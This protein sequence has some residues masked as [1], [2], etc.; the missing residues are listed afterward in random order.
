[1]TT[2]LYL[3]DTY[4][5]ELSANIITHVQD[6]NPYILL[7]R[8]IFYPQGGGQPSD[9][10]VVKAD[11]LHLEVL[12]VRQVEDEIRH[13]IAATDVKLVNRSVLCTIDPV[14]RILTA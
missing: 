13:Y 9:Q 7:D 2:R 5:F 12:Q 6:D 14:R 11:G 3:H 10:G 8:T 4:L 1:M